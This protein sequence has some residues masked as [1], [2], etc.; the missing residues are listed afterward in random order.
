L[1]RCREK[2]GDA[3]TEEGARKGPQVKLVYAT[4]CELFLSTWWELA[5]ILAML[6]ETFMGFAC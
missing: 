4:G 2:S 6:L 1:E 5:F 3:R